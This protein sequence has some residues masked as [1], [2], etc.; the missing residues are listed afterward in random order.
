MLTF[1]KIVFWLFLAVVLWIAVIRLTPFFDGLVGDV[2]DDD[3][4]IDGWDGDDG[5][6]SDCVAPWWDL[7]MHGE[8]VKAFQTSQSRQCQSQVRTCNDGQLSGIFGYSTC[9]VLIEP[10]RAD[11]FTPR[12]GRVAHGESVRAYLSSLANTANVCESEVR[13]CDNGVLQ[14]G[15][16]Y[17]SCEFVQD[18]VLGEMEVIP[19][20]ADDTQQLFVPVQPQDQEFIQ[21]PVDYSRTFRHRLENGDF[22]DSF[23]ANS[24][25][26]FISWRERQLGNDPSF[27]NGQTNLDGKLFEED[28]DETGERNNTNND[29]DT[30]DPRSLVE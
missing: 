9:K 1:F 19:G 11:C 17:Q 27:S 4:V 5:I 3:I 22:E 15:F 14:W 21:P 30:Y 18:G 13:V 8:S 29:P 16:V 12:W 25:R 23:Y 28:S 20:A 6:L 10:V 26:G 7:I 24:Y 2:V